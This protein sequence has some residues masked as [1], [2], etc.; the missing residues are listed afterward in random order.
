MKGFNILAHEDDR[1]PASSQYGGRIC[2]CRLTR[3]PRDTRPAN[4]RIW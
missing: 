1:E 4:E 2:Y 3:L